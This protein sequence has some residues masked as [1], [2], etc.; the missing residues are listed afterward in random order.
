MDEIS[1]VAKIYNDTTIFVSQFIARLTKSSLKTTISV[2]L[3]GI[4]LHVKERTNL[5]CWQ[6]LP[7]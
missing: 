1:L 7:V 6:K 5:R 3:V 2:G 4:S